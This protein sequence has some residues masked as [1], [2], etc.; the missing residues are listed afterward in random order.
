[1]ELQWSRGE[2]V[3]Y[4]ADVLSG[5][6]FSMPELRGTLRHSWRLFRQWRRVEAP[7]RAPPLTVW[8]VKAVIARALEIDQLAFAA[9]FAVGYH[10]LLRTGELLAL[11]F[12]GF[13][14]FFW[15]RCYQ[16]IFKQ[17]WPQDRYRG[18]RGREGSAGLRFTSDPCGIPEVLPRAEALAV[19]GPVLQ[20]PF[21]WTHEILSNISSSDE[22]LLPPEGR[23]NF[24]T[25]NWS[26]SG[27]NIAQRTLAFFKCRASLFT[28]WS[29]ATS[30]SAHWPSG[31]KET[32]ALLQ[33]VSSYSLSTKAVLGTVEQRSSKWWYEQFS[34][35]PLGETS[36]VKSVF[37]FSDHAI[38]QWCFK[39]HTIGYVNAR[40]I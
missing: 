32:G 27:Y 34:L 39:S 19:L 13:R 20:E 1:M 12:Q 33:S 36:S 14:T 21:C 35:M 17:K 23:S 40:R 30:T 18:S 37:S 7:Q 3:G 26:S 22:T 29:A 9:L 15:D 2:A 38:G 28:G 25:S 16:F 11:Q 31:S 6:H 24:F 8:I 10:C 4:I 5:L